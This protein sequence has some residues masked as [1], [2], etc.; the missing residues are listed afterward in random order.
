[1]KLFLSVVLWLA[2]LPRAISDPVGHA[3]Q[4]PGPG[5]SRSPCPMLNSLANHGYLPRN[6]L[7]ISQDMAIAAFNESVNFYNDI[8]LQAL[9]AALTLSTTGY[10]TTFNLKDTVAHS[11]IE[12]DASLSRQDYYFGDDLTFNATVWA[13]TTAFFKSG[14]VITLEEAAL[15]RAARIEQAEAIN[16][17][18]YFPDALDQNS[19]IET[20]LYIAIYG[21]IDSGNA[22]TSYVA[23]L[24]VDERIPYT[25]GFVRSDEVITEDDLDSIA[26]RIE[27][28]ASKK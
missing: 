15:A 25:E 12:H 8:L 27:A 9:G 18:F 20:S 24:F 21:D 2:A 13:N 14:D 4:A 10:D 5:D 26:G 16:P 17:T 23:A 3:W 6:G 1:M 7:N 28:V 19:L 22:T 11:V